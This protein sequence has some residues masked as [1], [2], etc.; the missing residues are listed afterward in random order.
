MGYGKVGYF[1]NRPKELDLDTICKRIDIL[2]E[3]IEEI[4]R[5]TKLQVEG[6]VVYF[7]NKRHLFVGE[8]KEMIKIPSD[9]LKDAKIIHLHPKGESFSVEDILEVILSKADSIVA[10]ND[11]YVYKMTNRTQADYSE[12]KKEIVAAIDDA[13]ERLLMLVKNGTITQSQMN[14]A[15]NHMVWQFVSKKVK[16]F[17][18][19][20][21][22]IKRK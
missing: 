8:S 14:F 20:A 22:T 13:E 5:K 10:F 21:Y 12:I 9:I 3:D 6:A 4:V 1:K 2:K 11:E 17:E 19:E 15:I 18:Y 16:G 7:N